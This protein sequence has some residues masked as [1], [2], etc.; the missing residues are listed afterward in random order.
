MVETSPEQRRECRPSEEGSRLE[1]SVLSSRPEFEALSS[2]WQRCTRETDSPFQHL[3]WILQYIEL[4]PGD[5]RVFL[6]EQ[7][8]EPIAAFPLRIEGRKVDLIGS[9]ICDF[10]DVICLPRTPLSGAVS[11]L[12]QWAH[13][14]G[15]FIDFRK[16]SNRGWLYGELSKPEWSQRFGIDDRIHG[17]CPFF[18]QM[19]GKTLQEITGVFSKSTRKKVRRRL[20]ILKEKFEPELKAMKEFDERFMAEAAVIHRERHH[21]DSLFSEE[22]FLPF[23]ASVMDREPGLIHCFLLEAPEH[24]IMGFEIGLIKNGHY[25]SWMGGYDPRWS[26]YGIGTCLM[27]LV[28]EHLGVRQVR[29]YDFL[30][31]G[32]SYK[33]HYNTGEYQVR[34]MSIR[35]R[36]PWNLAMLEVKRAFRRS[37]PQLKR[38]LESA[39]LYQTDYRIEGLGE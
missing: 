24:G 3:E 33:F 29:V 18:D 16:L 25:Y 23:L 9:D 31:G 39:G 8:G 27:A 36:T 34:S 38:V 17:P 5:H 11:G 35:T 32:E 37:K 7:F 4:F 14:N 21:S 30:C 2:W 22:G 10:Q 19:S 6:V 20:R 15:L 13:S 28:M 26:E 1:L 12:I